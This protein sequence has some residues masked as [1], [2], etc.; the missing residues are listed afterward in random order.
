LAWIGGGSAILGWTAASFGWPPRKNPWITLAVMFW[1]LLIPVPKRIG[2]RR[3]R[4][5]AD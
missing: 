5:I 4:R 2:R 1:L 3:D